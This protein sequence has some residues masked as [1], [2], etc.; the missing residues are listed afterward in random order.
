MCEGWLCHND[1]RQPEWMLSL[2]FSFANL[3]TA[4]FLIVTHG[5]RDLH[6]Y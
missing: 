5:V 6:G 3:L 4:E 2:P 1:I